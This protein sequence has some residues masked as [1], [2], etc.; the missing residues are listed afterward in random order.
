MNAEIFG[1]WAT[2][3]MSLVY[4]IGSWLGK[5][6]KDKFDKNNSVITSGN[7]SLDDMGIKDPYAIFYVPTHERLMQHILKNLGINWKDYLFVDL[8]SGKGRAL[9]MAMQYPFKK[10][11]GV[12]LSAECCKIS[13]A[14]VNV[15]AT[16]GKQRCGEVEICCMNAL[17]FSVPQG[18]NI[19]FYLYRP[20]IGPVLEQVLNRIYLS[21]GG[22]HFLIAHTCITPDV[23]K[24]LEDE[25]YTR[26]VRDF[27]SI[28][29]EYSWSLLECK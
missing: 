4:L 27:N 14:N 19:V 11:I 26:K 13:R 24:L 28:S 29:I 5:P 21:A 10:V 3:R 25:R 2:F 8:G 16:S 23:R 15:H 1:Y 7:L 6:P 18:E 22:N 12:E 17:D 20:F 9:L